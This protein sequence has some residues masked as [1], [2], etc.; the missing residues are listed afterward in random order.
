MEADICNI[1]TLR[2]KNR[3]MSWSEKGGNYLAKL[4]TARTSGE[5]YKQLDGIFDGVISETMQNEI[6]EVVQ[7]SAAQ[8]NRMNKENGTNPIKTVPKPYEGQV[9]TEG[10]KAIRD[11]VKNRIISDFRIY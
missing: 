9:L 10:R 6:I 5:L 11:L 7:L 2:M 8:A 4:L 3:K 1:I